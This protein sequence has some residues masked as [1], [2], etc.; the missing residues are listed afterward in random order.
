MIVGKLSPEREKELRIHLQTKLL[1][2][3]KPQTINKIIQD[4]NNIREGKISIKDP[5]PGL[6]G[7][8]TWFDFLESFAIEEF[9]TP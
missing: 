7:I 8:S 3:L 5:F 1:V 2:R 4:M 9:L 6:E